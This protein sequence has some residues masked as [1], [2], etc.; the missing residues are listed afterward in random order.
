MSSV[1]VEVAVGS[2]ETIRSRR[3]LIQLQCSMVKL[4]SSL[5]RLLSLL[6]HLAAAVQQR[7][8]GLSGHLTILQLARLQP[9]LQVVEIASGTGVAVEIRAGIDDVIAAGAEIDDVT[10]AAAGTDGADVTTAAAGVG[11][12]IEAGVVDVIVAEAVIEVMDEDVIV[13]AAGAA[14]MIVV[15][16]TT[17]V[18]IV[19]EALI[20]AAVVMKIV[21]TVMSQ[22]G[23]MRDKVNGEVVG[24]LRATQQQRISYSSSSSL[25]NLHQGV[26]HHH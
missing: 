10:E 17:E 15:V 2:V 9:L 26:D 12:V 16:D 3:L 11:D 5:V 23:K 21:N 7:L 13:A 20:G 25:S 6:G 22:L 4:R 18:G 24:M 1:V 14:D 19:A 8:L